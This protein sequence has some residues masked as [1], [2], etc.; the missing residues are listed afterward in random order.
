[1]TT[2]I[3][4]EDNVML[5]CCYIFPTLLYGV[6]AWTLK[7]DHMNNWETSKC[8]IYPGQLTLLSLNL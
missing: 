8:G 2:Y 6:E 4:T 1:M 3:R 5:L 7:K